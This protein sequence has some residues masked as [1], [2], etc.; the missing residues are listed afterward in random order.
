MP[1]FDIPIQFFGNCTV[2]ASSNSS[3]DR[4]ENLASCRFMG[5][6]QTLREGEIQADRLEQ[7]DRQTEAKKQGADGSKEKEADAVLKLLLSLYTLF[8][9][10]VLSLTLSVFVSLVLCRC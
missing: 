6:R 3:I 7:T 4:A 5:H 2:T 1:S 10:M 9:C 8:S